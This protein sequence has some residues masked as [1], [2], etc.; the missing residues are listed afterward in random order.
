[1]P[2]AASSTSAPARAGVTGLRRRRPRGTAPARTRRRARVVACRDADA[3]S[4]NSE[5]AAPLRLPLSTSWSSTFTCTNIAC[6]SSSSAVTTQG[7]TEI[8][9][10]RPTPRVRRRPSEPASR[11][12]ACSRTRRHAP[13]RR[14]PSTPRCRSPRRPWA[15]SR[16]TRPSR[17]HGTG[18]SG[19]TIAPLDVHRPGRQ[20]GTRE[21]RRQ[22]ARLRHAPVPR[23]VA[24]QGGT[25]GIHHAASAARDEIVEGRGEGR[26]PDGVGQVDHLALDDRSQSPV[27]PPV[28]GHEPHQGAE[29]YAYPGA[30][31]RFALAGST[32][33]HRRRSGPRRAASPAVD[34][35]RGQRPWRSDTMAAVAAFSHDPR[36]GTPGGGELP[37]TEKFRI[38]YATHVGGQRGAAGARTTRRPSGSRPTSART[39]RSS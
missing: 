18:C 35:R 2:S 12:P 22:D 20:Q 26:M 7:P 8:G 9:T 14:S 19:P 5:A 31:S 17:G 15:R 33:G 27:P 10:P 24:L 11:S 29:A 32:T 3:A 38:T 37:M 21:Q 25:G 4:S 39:T 23:V 6:G 13:R 34:R 1:M 30:I 28:V 36:P 16:A